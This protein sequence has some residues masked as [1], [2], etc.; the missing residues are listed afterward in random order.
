MLWDV[1]GVGED[2][3]SCG[4]VAET[5]VAA[6][7]KTFLHST[8]IKTALRGVQS[9]C[10]HEV[11]ST[12]CSP[13]LSASHAYHWCALIPAVSCGILCGSSTRLLLPPGI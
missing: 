2:L 10:D 12:T 4:S 3:S 6:G 11:F 8:A 9:L 5:S 13:F 1:E 7:G